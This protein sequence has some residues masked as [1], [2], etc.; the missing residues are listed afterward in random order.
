MCIARRVHCYTRPLTHRY[1]RFICETVRYKIVNIRDIWIGTEFVQFQKS[2]WGEELSSADKERTRRR[3]RFAAPPTPAYPQ[4]EAWPTLVVR[5]G[6]RRLENPSI[7]GW[8]DFGGTW[9]DL[10]GFWDGGILEGFCDRGICVQ[11]NETYIRLSR[12]MR[13]E[14]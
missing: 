7:L 14:K 3:P 10:E 12:K 9:R 4:P 6:G 1:S 13:P 5:T 2:V 11:K 8:R